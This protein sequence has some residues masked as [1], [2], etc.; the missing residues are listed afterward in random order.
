VTVISRD[1]DALRA[2]V[3]GLACDEGQ[4]HALISCDSNEPEE[5]RRRVERDVAERGPVHIL[6]NNSGGPPHGPLTEAKPEAFLKAMTMHLICYQVLA[7]TVL[8]GMKRA[9]Y[10]RIINITSLSVREPIKGL[11]VSNS[12]RWAVTAWAKT[13][14]GEVARF[15]IT[16][17]NILPGYIATS[18]LDELI[19]ARAKEAGTAEEQMRAN[20]VSQIPAGRLG[21][22]EELSAAAGFRLRRRRL[23]SRAS[24]CRWTGGGARRCEERAA[25]SLGRTPASQKPA[26]I[27]GNCLDATCCQ[28]RRGGRGSWVRRMARTGLAS[29]PTSRRGSATR[30]YMP[31]GT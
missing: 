8:P 2:V 12:T 25:V 3:G 4:W 5:M 6:L 18:R 22:P 17:N 23:M 10:G 14:A 24:T 29:K 26:L 1:E 11:G 30:S 28:A 21:E 13:L 20:M 15:G 7:Q 31:S 9:G 27:L 16:V 19:K